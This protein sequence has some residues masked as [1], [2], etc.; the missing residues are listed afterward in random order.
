MQSDSLKIFKI[1]ISYPIHFQRVF[2]ILPL[3]NSHLFSLGVKGGEVW[4]NTERKD[5]KS[6]I[7]SNFEVQMLEIRSGGHTW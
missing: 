4:M 1:Q 2:F 6:N 5:L 3:S 7:G